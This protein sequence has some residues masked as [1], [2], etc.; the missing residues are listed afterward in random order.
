M[1]YAA[2]TMPEPFDDRADDPFARPDIPV[3]GRRAMV[4]AAVACG[5]LAPW[6]FVLGL[7][8][9]ILGTLAHAKGDRYGLPAAFLSGF[10]LIA[11]MALVFFTRQ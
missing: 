2:A 6:L 8:G 7:I 4:V 9:M 11:G 3:R 5:L 1:A 10:G